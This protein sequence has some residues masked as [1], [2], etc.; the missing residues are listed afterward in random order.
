[1]V[2]RIGTTSQVGEAA[3]KQFG[4]Q[5]QVFFKTNLR[6]RFV[7]Q[8]AGSVAHESKVGYTTL[9]RFLRLQI[10]KDIELIRTGQISGCIWHFFRS[11]QTGRVG[12]SAPLLQ[13]LQQAGIHIQIY[14]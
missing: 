9:T 2:R 8:L 7:D 13:K 4:G 11:P 10:A 3:L 5:S 14:P 1:M 12:P 6:R